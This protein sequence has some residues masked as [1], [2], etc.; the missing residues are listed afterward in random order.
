MS[1]S[2]LNDENCCIIE[3]EEECS[4]HRNIVL[5][6]K[7]IMCTHPIGETHWTHVYTL[8]DSYS[9]SDFVSCRCDSDE[10]DA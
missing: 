4:I 3:Y 7:N 9:S 6:R 1:N 8:I 5:L 2:Y 10:E